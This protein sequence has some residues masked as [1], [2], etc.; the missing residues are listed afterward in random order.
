MIWQRFWE[1]ERYVQ[2]IAVIAL[3]YLQYNALQDTLDVLFVFD[4]TLL[5]E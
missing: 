2:Y 1:T 5:V 4:F 3:H